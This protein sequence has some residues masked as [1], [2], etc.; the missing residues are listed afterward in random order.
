MNNILVGI[1]GYARSGK[2][3][4][5]SLIRSHLDSLG[6]QTK[7]FSFAR[8]L[9]EDLDDFCTEKFKISAFEEDS[10]KK[11]KIRPLLVAY[12]NCQRN[13]SEGKYWMEKIKPYVDGFLNTNGPAVAIIT[14][15]RFKKYKFDE[16]D[17][18]RS[19]LKNCLFTV[20]REGVGPANSDESENFPFFESHADLNVK[21]S[22]SQDG[23][24]LQ[25]KIKPCIEAI[26]N[27][28]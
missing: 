16:Y 12:G 26:L 10:E 15:V 25:T 14:D 6:I 24:Y 9:K 20:S 5:A 2:D 7:T 13:I 1:A 3:T 19:F 18:V 22:S 17:F 28:L 21:W 8:E 4:M 27:K 11:S 23:D